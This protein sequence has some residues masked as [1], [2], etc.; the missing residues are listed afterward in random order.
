MFNNGRYPR[1]HLLGDNIV[2]LLHG[3]Q[4]VTRHKLENKRRQQPQQY[5]TGS[6]QLQTHL[7][8]AGRFRINNQRRYIRWISRCLVALKEFA[9][10][11]LHYNSLLVPGLYGRSKFKNSRQDLIGQSGP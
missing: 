2:L 1:G 7:A 6:Q 9:W 3:L 11:E 4:D 8:Q 10:R 5:D